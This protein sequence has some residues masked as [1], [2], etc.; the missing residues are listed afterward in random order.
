MNALY[1]CNNFESV[2]NNFVEFSNY[3]Y[4]MAIAQ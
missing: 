2:P 1:L 4:N 3:G